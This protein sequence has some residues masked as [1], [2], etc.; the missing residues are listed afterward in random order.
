MSNELPEFENSGIWIADTYDDFILDVNINREFEAR[1]L[2]RLALSLGLDADRMELANL[3]RNV[4][5]NARLY[6]ETVGKEQECERLWSELQ[7]M[8][9]AGKY[10]KPF[11]PQ[12]N[13]R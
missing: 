12:G 3:A 2:G 11:T 4:I 6:A 1:N 7:T 9:Q 8:A 10:C 13:E 5:E